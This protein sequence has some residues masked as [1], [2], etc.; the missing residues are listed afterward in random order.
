MGII[1]IPICTFVRSVGNDSEYDSPR[2]PWKVMP[3]LTAAA[4]E[5]RAAIARNFI[6]VECIEWKYLMVLWLCCRGKSFDWESW[7]Y[8]YLSSQQID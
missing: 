7:R 3:T 4:K 8:L 5:A 6:L 1:D 2:A